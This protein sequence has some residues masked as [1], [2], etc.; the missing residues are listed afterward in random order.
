MSVY[1]DQK[2]DSQYY[3]DNRPTY[4]ESLYKEI[5]SYHKGERET[6]VDVG[7]GTGISTFPLLKYFDHVI[8]T[9]PS[10]KMLE[11]ANDLKED[12]EK[13]NTEKTIK[14]SCSKAETLSSVIPADSVDLVTCAEAIQWI[15]TEK[16]IKEAYKVLKTNGTLAIWNYM[17]PSFI[18]YPK[19]NEIYEKFVFDDERYLGPCWPQ[20]GKSTFQNFCKDIKVPA[21]M[22]SDVIRVDYV[23]MK[24]NEKTAFQIARDDYTIADFR[25]NISSWSI[26]HIWQQRY[27][28]EGKDIADIFV[29]ELK[30]E[31]G[32]T[33]DT[34]LRV[35]WGTFYILARK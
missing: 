29:N 31:F 19:A 35:E 27:G 10:T 13:K 14:F 4:P 7:C 11:P 24:N 22:F 9:D 25:K 18:D 1:K 28:S 26:C 15:D 8:G 21:D 5:F 34:K 2:F 30:E 17:S 3:Q 20:P 12:F 16:F 6:A 33:D 23:P 32:W